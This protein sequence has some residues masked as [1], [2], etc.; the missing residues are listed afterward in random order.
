MLF[1]EKEIHQTLC[2]IPWT[3]SAVNARNVFDGKDIQ[4]TSWSEPW[5]ECDK[6]FWR[7]GNSSDIM[8][9]TMN[10][11]LHEMWKTFLT[12]KNPSD[13]MGCTMNSKCCKCDKRFLTRKKFNKH[14]VIYHELDVA[15]NVKNFFDEKKWWNK[16]SALAHSWIKLNAW[17]VRNFYWR[18]G[19][20][21]DIMGSTMEQNA[22]KSDFKCIH[23]L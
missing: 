18:K 8:F 17:N 19:I 23:E 1:D 11:M 6:R 12:R 14:Y 10:S 7:K 20:I 15:W 3:R 21:S 9:P 5:I 2:D 16:S 4:Q 22:V 13:I